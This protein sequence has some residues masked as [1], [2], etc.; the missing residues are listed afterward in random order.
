M[1]LKILPILIIPSLLIVGVFGFW[2]LGLI[3][4]GGQHRC[5]ISLISESNC[6]PAEGSI[7]LALHH[8]SGLKNF[9]QSVVNTDTSLSVLS[10]LLLC[11]LF[12]GSKPLRGTRVLRVLSRQIRRRVAESNRIPRKQFLRWL[13]LRHKRD[14]RICQWVYDAY[15]E[16]S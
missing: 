11:A 3:D 5:P 10:V 9:T 6:S 14:P 8:L 16:M 1:R 7:A 4:H 12:V 2:G 15:P 13:V